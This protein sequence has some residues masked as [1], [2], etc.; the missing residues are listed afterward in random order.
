[1]RVISKTRLRE[2]WV[3]RTAD[4]EIAERALLAWYE[5][6]K[7][8]EW[9]NF[10]AL[11]QTFGS[12][13]RVGNCVVFDIGNNRFRLI[14][15]ISFGR[16]I[17]YVLKVMDHSEYDKKLWINECGCRKPPPNKLTTSKKKTAPKEGPIQRWRKRGQ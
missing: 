9:P 7:K 4:S 17:V 6:A 8:A 1:V 5:L 2:F 12:A 13:D 16:G 11:K 3:D 14:G 10:G 15:R